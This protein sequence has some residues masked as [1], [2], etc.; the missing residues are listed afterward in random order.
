[1]EDRKFR[2]KNTTSQPNE[3]RKNRYRMSKMRKKEKT[4]FCT[5][6]FVNVIYIICNNK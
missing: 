6:Y 2:E 3:N 5:H 1:M 4:W